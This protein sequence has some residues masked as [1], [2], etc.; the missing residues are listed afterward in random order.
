MLEVSIRKRIAALVNK[1]ESIV[2][3]TQNE[4]EQLLDIFV[5]IEGKKPFAKIDRRKFREIL[6]DTFKMTDDFLLDR[7]YRA[8]DINNDGGISALEWVQGLSV[9]LR[10]TPADKA[11]FSFTAY[12]LNSDGI[13]TREEM[14]QLLKNSLVK[15]PTDEDPDEGVRELVE[16]AFKLLDI[17]HDGQVTFNNFRTAVEQDP[18]VLEILGPCFP[19]EKVAIAFLSSFQEI[20]VPDMLWYLQPGGSST[21]LK[22]V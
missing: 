9:F 11:K 19:E 5:K 21:T 17:D 1:L 22:S 20:Q 12:D 7:V 8:F 18:L 2:N 3:F 15:Q 6:H 16:I 13:I 4:I 10:G 14:F